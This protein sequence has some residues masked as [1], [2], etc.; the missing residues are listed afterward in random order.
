MKVT[1]ITQQTRNPS[2]VN[3]SI[4]GVYRLSLD[5]SQVVELGV[6]VGR[7]YEG[8]E[9]ATLESESQF[10]KLYARALEYCLMRP[11]SAREV[12]EYLYRKTKATHYKQKITG[13]IKERVGVS[14]AIADRVYQR[15]VD[16]GYI[17]DEKFARYWVEHRNQTRGVSQRKLQAELFAKGVASSVVTDALAV[18]E[19]H[20]EDEL[21]KVIAKKRAKYSDNQKFM[22]YLA[23]QG[24]SY[25]DIKTALEK[26]ED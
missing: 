10:G 7:E 3:I 26:N 19:R 1:S 8:E 6:K 23:R 24:F 11:H 13:E 9:L 2:R 4:D 21:A 14:R 15:L 25:D 12:R 16:K 20:D 18:T 22:H 17:D 5:I